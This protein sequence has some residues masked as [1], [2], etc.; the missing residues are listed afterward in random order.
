MAIKELKKYI[1]VA[2]DADDF[3]LDLDFNPNQHIT[4][5]FE[6][7]KDDLLNLHRDGDMRL[8]SVIFLFWN[9]LN[10]ILDSVKEE[11]N[12]LLQFEKKHWHAKIQARIWRLQKKKSHEFAQIEVYNESKLS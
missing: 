8:Y 6:S 5:L 4:K 2:I 11:K 10:G 1:D 9:K 3:E 7:E 12:Q